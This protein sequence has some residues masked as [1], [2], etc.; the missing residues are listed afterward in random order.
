MKNITM[1]DVKSVRKYASNREMT[2]SFSFENSRLDWL[3]VDFLRE[4]S[5]IYEHRIKDSKKDHD[6]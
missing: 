6:S 3:V 4:M 5:D 1:E 2:L